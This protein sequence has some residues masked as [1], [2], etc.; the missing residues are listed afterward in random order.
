MQSASVVRCICEPPPLGYA[1]FDYSRADRRL[2]APLRGFLLVLWARDWI[3]CAWMIALINPGKRCSISAQR[4]VFC[5]STPRRS[6]RI[7][8]AWR[9]AVKCWERVD[10]GMSLSTTVRKSEQR[11]E[12]C[13]FAICEKIATRTGS[14][15]AWR[16]ASTV[17]SSIEG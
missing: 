1:R 13:E 4:E 16:I 9:K 11:C 17:T 8:P 6:P 7:K 2:G 10:F 12:H 15:R 3:L 14:E 5:I